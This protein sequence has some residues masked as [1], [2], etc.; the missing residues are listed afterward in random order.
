MG[1]IKYYTD[2]SQVY[3]ETEGEHPMIKF[4]KLTGADDKKDVYVNINK[5][6]AISSQNKR[7]RVVCVSDKWLLV[8]ETVEEILE[9]I[10]KIK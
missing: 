6:N 2:A 7:V 5:I 3:F 1:M 8:L 9:K 10:E 4:I